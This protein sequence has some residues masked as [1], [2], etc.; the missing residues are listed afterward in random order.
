[1]DAEDLVPSGSVVDAGSKRHVLKEV[2]HL[3][4]DTVWIVDVLLESLGTFLAEAMELVD[5]SIFVV[6]AKKED[7]LWIFELEG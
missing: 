4:K 5:V 2:I 1:M 7:L 6:A 3:L